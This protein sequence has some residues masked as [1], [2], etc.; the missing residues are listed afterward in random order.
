MSRTH[1]LMHSPVLYQL[2]SSI[3]T[4]I[5]RSSV[6]MY[7]FLDRCAVTDKINFRKQITLRSM[8][9]N[10]ETTENLDDAIFSICFHRHIFIEITIN[11]IFVLVYYIAFR[12]LNPLFSLHRMAKLERKK[13]DC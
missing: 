2:A 3:I 7:N 4:M 13:L 8:L 12:V 9:S 5:G 6:F 1:F 10:K 11:L